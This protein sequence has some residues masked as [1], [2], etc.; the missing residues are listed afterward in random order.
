MIDEQNNAA[1]FEV[2]LG[3]AEYHGLSKA[4]VRRIVKEVVAAVSTWH[5]DPNADNATRRASLSADR[6]E[7]SSA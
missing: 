1:S 3:T 2:V 4:D 7:N 6:N 5:K